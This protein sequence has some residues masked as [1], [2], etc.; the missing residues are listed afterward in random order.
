MMLSR[1]EIM[2][3]LV[4]KGRI[5]IL[6]WFN[7]F[8][9]NNARFWWLSDCSRRSRSSVDATRHW[10]NQTPVD[11]PIS[12]HY[13]LTGN[14]QRFENNAYLFINLLLVHGLRWSLRDF[15]MTTHPVLHYIYQHLLQV[16]KYCFPCTDFSTI[17][18][19]F[20]SK[21]SEAY[22]FQVSFI[23]YLR[24][25]TVG[26][27]NIYCYRI[28]WVHDGTMHFLDTIL[29]SGNGT[30]VSSRITSAHVKTIGISPQRW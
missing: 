21:K 22:L 28:G 24:P 16:H 26:S 9:R 8:P 5:N 7:Y 19:P 3:L 14:G 23:S 25:V 20:S 11:Y 1:F 10:N 27:V 30:I 17:S 2:V 12:T 29:S 18:N 13:Q 4:A 15:C 6:T